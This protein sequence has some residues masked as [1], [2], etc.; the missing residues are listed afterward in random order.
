[1]I[2]F[3]EKETSLSKTI[4]KKVLINGGVW[5]KKLNSKKRIRIRR[6]TSLLEPGAVIEFYFD[7]KFLTLPVLNGKELSKEKEWGFWYKPPGLLSQGTNYGDHASLL[8]QIEIQKKNA[9]LIHRLD[10]EAHGLMLFAYN[11]HAARAFSNLWQSGEVRKF[12]KVE[13]LGNIEKNYSGSKEITFKL[14]E[15]EARTSFTLLEQKEYTSILLVEIHTGRLHQI[16]RHFE[17]IGFPVMGDPVYGKG[18]KNNEGIRL[19]SY[20]LIFINPLT[21]KEINFILPDIV[22]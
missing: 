12:Y 1:M 16:R 21:K 8:R 20:Q 4:L 5:I 14:D 22:F 2:D 9:F 7:P 6:A 3:L 15:K 10:R 11:H 18:N 17:K 13:V 19:M